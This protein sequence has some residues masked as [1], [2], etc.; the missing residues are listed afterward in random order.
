MVTKL[1][2][3][4][5]LCSVYAL[6]PHPVLPRFLHITRGQLVCLAAGPGCAG[7]TSG[8][9]HGWLQFDALDNFE[10]YREDAVLGDINF[11][12]NREYANPNETFEYFLIDSAATTLQC[13]NIKTFSTTWNRNYPGAV[14]STVGAVGDRVVYI[15]NDTIVVHGINVPRQIYIDVRSELFYGWSLAMVGGPTY[16]YDEWTGVDAFDPAIFKRPTGVTC[17]VPPPPSS[18]AVVGKN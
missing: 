17:V 16:I 3:A 7:P 18:H 1:F 2:F 8:V 4:L 10:L 13:V 15:W 5:F 6:G 9:M 14:Y 12:Y 11:V